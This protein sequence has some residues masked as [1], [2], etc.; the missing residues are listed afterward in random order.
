MIDR[1]KRFL[2]DAGTIVFATTVV[3]WGLL[4]FPRPEAI[5]EQYVQKAIE[6]QSQVLSQDRQKEQ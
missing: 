1:R 2:V 3:I 6:I 4:Y 5:A